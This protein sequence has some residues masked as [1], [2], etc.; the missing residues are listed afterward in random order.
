MSGL[1]AFL[2]VAAVLAVSLRGTY[3]LIRRAQAAESR[4]DRFIR[5]ACTPGVDVW[6]DNARRWI[7]LPP[8]VKPG[9]GQYTDREVVAL[10]QLELAWDA[11]AYGE[12]AVDPAWAAGLE[13]LRDAIRDHHTNAP[14]G[15]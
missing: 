6:D 11:P 5:E 7:T 13:R 1:A 8:G 10:D 4:R 12:T 3:A 2:I 9:L 15:D 14:E